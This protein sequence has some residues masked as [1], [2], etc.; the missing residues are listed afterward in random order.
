MMNGALIPTRQGIM[1]SNASDKILVVIT[2]Q[3]QGQRAKFFPLGGK[4]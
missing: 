1:A 2:N 4:P 3:A